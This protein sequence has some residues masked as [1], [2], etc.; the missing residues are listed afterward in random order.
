MVELGGKSVRT[1]FTNFPPTASSISVALFF[2]HHSLKLIKKLG[3]ALLNPKLF[4]CFSIAFRLSK[5]RTILRTLIWCFAKSTAII[6]PKA[7]A[8]AVFTT[9]LWW[10]LRA[11]S[12]NARNGFTHRETTAGRRHHVLGPGTASGIFGRTSNTFS[13]KDAG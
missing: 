11:I 13:Q 6:L 8:A 12:R 9:A 10:F 4:S 3:S 2:S 7:P 1:R 5:F